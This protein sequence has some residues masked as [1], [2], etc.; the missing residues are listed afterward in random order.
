MNP[1]VATVSLVNQTMLTKWQ[2]E[3]AALFN[4]FRGEM[5][6]CAEQ[7][8]DADAFVAQKKGGY[9]IFFVP[10]PAVAYAVEVVGKEIHRIAP[11]VLAYPGDVLHT[12]FTDYKVAPHF[13][14]SEAPDHKHVLAAFD[15]I[16]CGIAGLMKE[17]ASPPSARYGEL[18]FSKNTFMLEGFATGSS[19]LEGGLYVQEKGKELLGAELRLPWGSHISFGRVARRIEPAKV[20]RLIEYCNSLTPL[21]ASQAYPFTAVQAGWYTMSPEKGFQAHITSSFKL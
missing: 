18:L 8:M 20:S 13:I 21:M 17:R 10:D 4:K 5:L 19:H 7:G 2:A 11:E 3:S 15:E 1:K 12:T 6:Q 16:A 14:P 9:Y